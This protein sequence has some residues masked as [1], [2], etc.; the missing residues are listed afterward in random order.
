VLGR[1]QQILRRRDRLSAKNASTERGGYIYCSNAL[2]RTGLGA[3][4]PN[5]DEKH[6]NSSYNDLKSGA[7]KRRVHVPVP[8]PANQQ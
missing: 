5:S 7:K 8:N 2:S 6:Q 1:A 4:D 3:S